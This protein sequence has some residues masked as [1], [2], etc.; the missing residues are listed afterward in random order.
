LSVYCS[1]DVLTPSV[2]SCR[3][4]DPDQDLWTLLSPM[5]TCRIG[6]GLAVVNRLL[7][8]VGG[9]DGV[10]RLATVERY[11][12]EN[13]DWQMVAPMGVTRSGAGKL[14]RSIAVAVLPDSKAN[15]RP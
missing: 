8:V 3:R 5:A 4:Y 15:L 14:T 9:Y 2:V 12:P 11:H 7:Y 1:V 10:S 6:V 13:D